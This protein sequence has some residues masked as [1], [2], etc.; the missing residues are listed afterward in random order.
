MAQLLDP[1]TNELVEVPDDEALGLINSGKL[2]APKRYFD[3]NNKLLLQKGDVTIPV[4]DDKAW[5]YW[6]EGYRLP[7]LATPEDIAFEAY[8]A[9]HGDKVLE[10]IGVGLSKFATVSFG[11]LL[12]QQVAET[13][14]FGSDTAKSYLEAVD[15]TEAFSPGIAMGTDVTATALTALLTGGGS[16]V[17]K[18][19]AGEVGKWAVK[20]GLKGVA[21]KGLGA[22]TL[23]T[24][25]SLA[26]GRIAGQAAGKAAE[27]MFGKK[28][29]TKAAEW[30][31]E[32]AV[33]GAVYGA[34]EELWNAGIQNREVLSQEFISEAGGRVAKEM[35]LSGGISAAFPIVGGSVKKVSGMTSKT[36]ARTAKEAVEAV[37][38]I[39]F[40]DSYTDPQK[41][42]QGIAEETSLDRIVTRLADATIIT[43][44]EAIDKDFVQGL[45]RWLVETKGADG[46][47]LLSGEWDEI[48]T[49]VGDI[50]AVEGEK[51]GSLYTNLD[52]LVGLNP[53][54][55][56]PV[57]FAR[58]IEAIEKKKLSLSDT[59]D[60]AVVAYWDERLHLAKRSVIANQLRR[61]AADPVLLKRTLREFEGIEEVDA[62]LKQLDIEPA[63]PIPTI[64]ETQFAKERGG[65]K[66]EPTEWIPE[67]EGG[68]R[69][70][71]AGEVIEEPLDEAQEKFLRSTV[72]NLSPKQVDALYQKA[73][74][75][76][77][78]LPY[79]AVHRSTVDLDKAAKNTGGIAADM[80]KDAATIYRGVLKAA[81]RDG[82]PA[83]AYKQFEIAN[84]EYG[85]LKVLQE[86][87]TNQKTRAM[88]GGRATVREI[89]G[90]GML[91]ST[92]DMGA[93]TYPLA[94]AAVLGNRYLG[95]R[96]YDLTMKG[97]ERL[98]KMFG[99][100]ELK[101]TGKI[102]SRI[103]SL[104][105]VGKKVA[106]TAKTAAISLNAQQIER[107]TP[108]I[109]E[110]R[111]KA[112]T[113]KEAMGRLISTIEHMAENPEVL[114]TKLQ[115]DLEEL[116]MIAPDI[117]GEL[118]ATEMRKLEY[119]N[120]KAPK[121]EVPYN[122]LQPKLY[123][124]NHLNKESMA[125]FERC[126]MATIAPVDQ[127]FAEMD[128]GA[129][130][131]DT[132]EAVKECY[133]GLFE[134]IG[135][136]LMEK[137]A[138]ESTPRT[139]GFMAQLSTF[140]EKPVVGYQSQNFLRRQQLVYA[141]EGGGGKSPA[142]GLRKT[143]A[144][145]GQPQILNT[146][147]TESAKANLRKA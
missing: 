50:V 58:I 14:G 44:K 79:E 69:Q 103:D 63:D 27:K 60:K 91:A 139:A 49:R 97:T 41:F 145:Q 56:K 47:P 65:I 122:D 72:A 5:A 8:E 93:M 66:K 107:I 10:P 143:S 144:A 101:A 141:K 106:K 23:G 52:S 33:D 128:K 132:V 37:T 9:E 26:G 6:Q 134:K 48:A 67:D 36:I 64:I 110:P 138:E 34:R 3:A 102:A 22:A 88:T 62:W 116:E 77:P 90:A 84:K 4:D 95:D 104:L 21:K 31:V 119:L 2:Q 30:G 117:A 73:K 105:G 43:D 53:E 61:A 129:L 20:K 32:G 140:Y 16:V 55:Y 78:G 124:D 13:D 89:L 7:Q 108:D 135:Q 76:A 85:Y 94:G 126:I 11:P 17:A 51:I 82:V 131:R 29:A 118:A 86:I 59:A 57:D 75:T 114:A 74:D 147:N 146:T 123:A 80:A 121:L 109:G 113:K 71:A 54:K 83:D 112:Q 142:P 96:A 99:K 98:S 120:Y 136:M 92:V 25:A 68:F 45:K 111:K 46:N 39:R 19:V 115:R 18:E 133:P 42:L 70:R 15:R 24:R 100:A 127:I 1:A 81:V 38:P 125:T 87:S 35:L 130:S 12:A 137:T 40:P 28:L